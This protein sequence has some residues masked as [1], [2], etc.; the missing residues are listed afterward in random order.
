MR[1]SSISFTHAST[2]MFGLAVAGYAALRLA[3]YDVPHAHLPESTAPHAIER[4]PD[5]SPLGSGSARQPVAAHPTGGHDRGEH[6]GSRD[7]R[8]SASPD[9][10]TAAARSWSRDDREWRR[11]ARN[12]QSTRPAERREPSGGDTAHDDSSPAPSD[13]PATG[14]DTTDDDS[15]DGTDED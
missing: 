4:A 14:G 1:L 12:T 10:R 7:Q 15:G 6:T 2:A 5:V 8:P 9:A 3:G 13:D 11:D